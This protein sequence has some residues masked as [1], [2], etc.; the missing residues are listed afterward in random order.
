MV[1][2]EA[3]RPKN[4]SGA[5]S[6]ASD[7][8]ATRKPMP[9]EPSSKKNTAKKDA[10][11]KDALRK[12]A[13]KNDTAKKN[14]VNSASKKNAVNAV[15]RDAAQKDT[16]KKTPNS[17]AKS[18]P[19]TKTTSDIPEAVSRRMIRRM[20]LF[21]GIP[22]ALG[23]ST[24]IISYLVVS[25]DLFALPT[26][27]VLLVSL[28]WFGLGVLGLSYGVLSSSWE[29][30]TPGSKLGLEEFKLNWSRTTA[31]WREGTRQQRQRKG[32]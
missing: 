28:G 12:D 9:F 6:G 11:K 24:F 1:Q 4:E 18:A 31:A 23:M 3:D 10:P 20:A 8:A 32:D 5:S 2:P 15:N 17:S 16:L 22:S 19:A 26:Y 7:D 29:E 30:D 27:A 13:V 25:Q 21:C 14:T